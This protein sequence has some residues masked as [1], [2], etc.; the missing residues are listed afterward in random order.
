MKSPCAIASAILVVSLATAPAAAAAYKFDMGPEGSP[1]WPG[2]KL[3]S[4]KMMYTPDRG[5]G[6]ASRGV[7]QDLKNYQPDDLARDLVVVKR[8]YPLEF[9]IKIAN[10][11]Y[12]VWVI[13]GDD[14]TAG[15]DWNRSFHLI[16]LVRVLAE[17]KEV[18][19]EQRDYY[20]LQDADYVPGQS[21]WDKY[22]KGRYI[23]A[24]FPVKV[25][26]GELNL[27]FEGLTGKIKYCPFPVN[28]IV[29]FPAQQAADME[30]DI[31]KI[32]DERKKAFLSR[33]ARKEPKIETPALRVDDEAKR[34]G[35]VVFLKNYLK[36]VFP[37]TTPEPHEY[38]DTIRTFAA[39]GEWEPV[40]FCIRPIRDLKDVTVTV[41]GLRSGEARIPA[42]NIR[43]S[44]VKYQEKT[45]GRG[46]SY[47]VAPYSLMH[48]WKRIDIPA[49]LTKQYWLKMSIPENASP[50]FYDGQ[51]AIAPANAPGK[52]LKLQLRVLP[53]KLT[54]PDYASWFYF[55]TR[56]R[57]YQDIHD[58][59][60]DAGWEE[61]YRKESDDLKEHGF[62]IAPRV[63][64]RLFR[65]KL[66]KETQRVLE[67]DFSKLDEEMTLRRK[68]GAMPADGFITVLCGGFANI[69]C[70]AKWIQR[71]VP[72]VKKYVYFSDRKEDAGLFR[73][74]A[75]AV[76][77][78]IRDK[79]YGIPVF[80]CGGELT[81][82]GEM[83]LTYG[84]RAYGALKRA[85][86]LTALR[87]NGWVDY[88]LIKAG[89]VDYA[90][91]NIAL[92]RDEWTDTMK[93]KCK[94][95]WLY[96][97][98]NGRYGFGFFAWRKGATRRLHEGYICCGGRPWDDFDAGAHNWYVG[99]EGTRDGVVSRI[100]FEHMAE[101]RDD[102][103]YLYTCEQLIQ[104]AQK[105]GSAA[106]REAVAE[107]Q[108][109]LKF[110]AGRTF[111][112]YDYRGDIAQA[113]GLYRDAGCRWSP[114]DFQKYRWLVA[115]EIMRLQKVLE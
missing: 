99:V 38:G 62:C 35:Y 85:G 57:I 21:I 82:Y 33:W 26:D 64:F 84:K 104:Q 92:I 60:K 50:G 2:F 39:Q 89:L 63:D 67:T 75:R 58:R 61:M 41:S 49:G 45:S 81:N 36:L 71:R 1:V 70:G 15:G 101:G 109:T 46:L 32:T 9:R 79:A 11:H 8:G 22:I 69:H 91:P 73:E 7:V 87:G 4:A 77:K 90:I 107:A 95:L 27:V 53:F 43:V 52:T 5:F 14:M 88:E 18:F 30:R 3:V 23:E 56:R 80:E 17:G 94:G 108:R 54:R 106:A 31:A 110:I 114:D 98:S 83:G 105:K 76:D 28:A 34:L 100:T 113:S 93:K 44:V 10:G 12:R 20:G 16:Q 103:D 115:R 86:V 25:T 42:D 19:R 68:I 96:N 13:S 59:R 66:D 111:T 72:V 97:F 47:V 74:I 51:I 48:W 29:V 112:D 65:L 37:Q 102:F 55:G 24:A 40:S 78:H 6:W